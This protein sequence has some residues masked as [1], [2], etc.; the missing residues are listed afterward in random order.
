MI[1]RVH[2][3][4]SCRL[5]QVQRRLHG[6]RLAW[7]VAV[8]LAL[9][10]GPALRAQQAEPVQ[11]NGAPAKTGQQAKPKKDG[12]KKPVQD[13]AG[14]TVTGVRASLQSAQQLKQNAD[15]IVDSVTAVDIGALPDRSVTET[16]QRVSGV[17]IDHFM[18]RNDP[19]HFSAEGSGVM[20]RGLTQVRGELNGRD[21]FSANSG[22]G[23]SFEDV[24]AELMAGV[25][26]YKNP[27]AEIIEGGIGGTVNLRT[28]LPFDSPGRVIG[29]TG[30]VN[31]G[32][33]AKKSKPSA[34][35]LYSN[36]WK[37]ENHGEFG[38][39]FDVAFSELATRSDGI[40]ME[41]Y[42]RRND[43][44]VLKGTNFTNVYVPGGADWRTLDFQRRRIGLAGALQWRPNKNLE[45]TSQVLRSDYRMQWDEFGGIFNDSSNN[46]HPANGGTFNYDSNGVFQS[47]TLAS[48]SWRGNLTTDGV[49][50]M[51]DRRYATQRTITTD[52][53]NSL[54][55][56]IN[57]QMVLYADAQFVKSTSQSLDFTVFDATYLPGVT[58]NVPG[59]SKPTITSDPAAYA[60]NPAN[61]FWSAAMDH[62]ERNKGLERALRLD[63]EY[64]FED[65][66]WLRYVK[67]GVRATSR[68]E[69]NKNNGY[70]W[71]VVSDNWAAI[72]SPSG[73]ADLATYL[74][75]MS[76]LY[77]YSNFFRGNASMPPQLYFPSDKLVRDY[78]YAYQQLHAFGSPTGW[79]PRDI[80]RK[81]DVN[82]QTERT[83]SAYGVLYFGSDDALG[84][85]VDGNVGIRLVRTDVTAN[86][87]GQYPD[88]TT[89]GVDPSLMAMYYGQYFPLNSSGHYK[90]A[91]PSFNLRFKFTD[92]LQWRLAASRA[93]TR[94]DFT[95]LQP[96][97]QM[98]ATL[99]SDNTAV[100]KWNGSA[101]NPNLKP[102]RA[103][104]YDTALE[105]YFAPTG[106]LYAT[107]FYKDVRDY[108]ANQTR[109][110]IYNGQPFEVTRPYNMSKGKIRGGEIGYQQFFDFLPGWLK[111]F[112]VQAN[113]TYV[114]S[115]GGTNS[116]T[117]PYSNTTVTGVV[118]PLEGLSKRSYNL[119]G[120]YEYGDWSMRLAWNWRSRY[121]LTA[122][123]VATKL[124]TWS[125][126]YGQ[127][128]GSIMYRLNKSVQV[129]LQTNNLTNSTTK[130]L[131]G[132]TS[133]AD[134]TVDHRLYNRGWFV[135]DRR[136]ELV[137]R[138][139]F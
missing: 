129:G 16:L 63:L 32:D 31:E 121:L 118:L 43:D 72:D 99:T 5:F 94:P 124:P 34:S 18:A 48:D 41:P 50:F 65:S 119:V 57:D 107:L 9:S 131:M 138:A 111:G 115:K 19:D 53:S 91:L 136:Y 88:L 100:T 84:V 85:P 59:G 29:F 76:S 4:E 21:V 74:P 2:G 8:G 86:G 106:Q 139:T 15:Q 25:D 123:D 64:N 73:L 69:L 137:V 23:L 127:L 133:Y 70:N 112:G 10:Y 36:V 54:K 135:N 98:G 82:D 114:D 3:G 27:S 14:V 97:L 77:T 95:Q 26:V 47:G 101:G 79:A 45:L 37:T 132:P 108:I 52:W 110:E 28:R 96:Y 71:G 46:V 103:N 120:M 78:H 44:A 68:T 126:D 61:Y 35:F 1:E 81:Q 58:L 109:T 42:V 128:D 22:R 104:Q 39:L 87:Y 102:M 33:F 93:M 56:N 20:I 60:T 122:S 7:A 51:A 116:A 62:H 125:D 55:Y 105:W 67:F 6:T 75:S 89:S 38:A 83:K 130:V 66:K 90:N 24:P 134:G 80:Y 30:G 13:L 40:Q 113:F 49:R 17:T 92:S 11:D 12:D 117:D